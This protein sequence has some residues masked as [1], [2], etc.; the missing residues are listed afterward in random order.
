MKVNTITNHHEVSF[1]NHHEV[2][3]LPFLLFTL[4]SLTMISGLVLASSIVSADDNS[5][6]DR[7]NITVPESC[8]MSGT[9]MDS[10]NT[11][12]NNG[13]Y[14]PDIGTTTMHVFCNDNEGFAIY[15]AGYTGDEIGGENSNKLVGT[16]ASNNATIESGTATSAGNPDISNWAMKLAITQDSGDTTETNAFVIDSAP[17]VALPSTAEQSATPVSFSEYHVVPNEYVKVA[18]KNS[19]TDMTDTTGGVK[20]NTTYAAYISKTQ[21]AD[22]YSG[23]VIYTL[24]HPSSAAPLSREQV[25]VTYDA[26]GSTF[27]GGGTTNR[28]VYTNSPMYIATTPL[29]AKTANVGDD[30]TQNGSYTT[31]NTLTPI[32]ATG[33]SKMKVVIRYGLSSGTSLDIIEGNYDGSGTRGYSE[34]LPTSSTGEATYVFN[35]DAVTFDMHAYIAPTS[36]DGQDYGYYAEVYPIYATEQTG[37][38]PSAEYTIMLPEEGTYVQT[39]GWYGSWYADI[40]NQHYDF[41]NEAEVTEFLNSNIATLGGVDIDLYRGL[42]F[43]EAYTRA[44]KTQDGGYYKQQDLNND[45]CQTVA[46]TQNQTVKDVRD[47]NIYMI[48]RLKDGRCWMLDNLALDPTDVAMA[49]NMSA[50][51]TN[52]SAEAIT[53]YL[54]GGSS[55]TGWSSVAVLNKTSS[56][57]SGDGGYTQPWVNNQSTN[58]LVTGYGPASTNG[59]AK[60]G[61]YYNYCAATVGTYCYDGS[62]GVD[63]PDTFIDA[64]QDVCPANWR[65]PTGGMDGE[66]A[67]L[68]SK[69][70]ST[71]DATSTASLQYNLSA[72]LSGNFYNNSAGGQGSSGDWWTSTWRNSSV[73]Y[74]LSVKSTSIDIDG[75]GSLNRYFGRSIRC[76][77]GN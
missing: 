73:M 18:H 7:I 66:Y 41:M 55:T 63:L 15:A 48:G 77:V 53:N 5:T 33:A 59:Q 43:A 62:S 51:N 58:T 47:D 19:V 70:N 30:G 54:N 45:M 42:T 8:T 3:F 20:L 21:P 34:W 56:W 39:T 13:T 76:L 52:A 17:N 60:V 14:T 65:M 31:G 32:A 68:Y 16:T 24:I 29:I 9:G 74:F 37:S 40:N 6:V 1:C 75:Y 28:V 49:T 11:N 44:G 64:P 35:G 38:E 22:T 12:I 2:S 10:H 36:A 61:V 50:D 57:T 23:K 4:T 46:I 67:M 25:G 72:I 69:Y 71:Q 27:A 26:N